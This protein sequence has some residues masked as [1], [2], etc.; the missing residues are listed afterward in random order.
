MRAYDAMAGRH[1]G[2]MDRHHRTLA[3]VEG[4]A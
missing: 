3:R 2:L 1:A 4:M